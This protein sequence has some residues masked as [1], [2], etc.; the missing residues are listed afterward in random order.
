MFFLS[1]SNHQFHVFIV[2][3]QLCTFF[4]FL[5]IIALYAHFYLYIYV[6]FVFSSRVCYQRKSGPWE[7]DLI[8]ILLQYNNYTIITSSFYFCVWI[9]LY[10]QRAL[11]WIVKCGCGDGFFIFIHH[12]P[13]SKEIFIKKNLYKKKR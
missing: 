7:F 9:I 10:Y 5:Y 6:Y 8:F 2:F 12:T 3:G 1:L 4:I 11:K 13:S